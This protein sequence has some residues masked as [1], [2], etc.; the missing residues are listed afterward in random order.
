MI[1]FWSLKSQLSVDSNTAETWLSDANGDIKQWIFQLIRRLG[2]SF[3]VWS[4]GPRDIW[5]KTVFENLTRLSIKR[6]EIHSL[7][8]I[9]QK[10]EI[11]S[12]LWAKKRSRE[13]L[14]Q[15]QRQG[16]RDRWPLR[17]ICL[18]NYSTHLVAFYIWRRHDLLYSLSVVNNAT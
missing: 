15:G 11:L 6:N 5:R 14:T 10:H 12:K 4:S 17:L 8:T 1:A 9:H 2:K 13:K 7:G 3:S 16:K 18:R